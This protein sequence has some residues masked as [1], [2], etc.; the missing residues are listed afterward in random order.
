M[1]KRG[2]VVSKNDTYV[3]REHID[4]KGMLS[5]YIHQVENGIEQIPKGYVLGV[6]ALYYNQKVFSE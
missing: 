5:V 2:Y 6:N 1:H 3:I 4:K